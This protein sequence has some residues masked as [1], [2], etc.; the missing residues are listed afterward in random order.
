MN[1]RE[2]LQPAPILDA[3]FLINS[4]SLVTYLNVF[5]PPLV[6]GCKVVFSY[7]DG[8]ELCC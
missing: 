7:G 5:F 2:F 6:I 1:Q 3:L 8:V 4:G